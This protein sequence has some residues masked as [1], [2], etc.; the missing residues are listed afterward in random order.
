[1]VESLISASGHV[2]EIVTFSLVERCSQGPNLRV[3]QPGLPRAPQGCG[4]RARPL[5]GQ[6]GLPRRGLHTGAL[7]LGTLR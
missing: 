5:C 1:M 4:L 7:Q 6:C 2:T 3:R